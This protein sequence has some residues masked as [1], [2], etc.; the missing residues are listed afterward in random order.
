MKIKE[1][2]IKRYGPLSHKNPVKLSDFN[3][4]W[5]RNEEGKTLTIDALVKFILGKKYKNKRKK[6][7]FE[8]I[9]RVEEFP[10]GYAVI[11]TNNKEY[12]LGDRHDLLSLRKDLSDREFRNIFVIR[13][14]D[15][16]LY[17]ESSFYSSMIDK[18]TG[19]RT[20]DIENLKA[21][22]KSISGLTP[23]GDFKNDDSS[24]KLKD[25]LQKARKLI[26]DIKSLKK[27]VKEK[28][29]NKL[30]Y[31]KVKLEEEIDEIKKKLD[32]L[33]AALKKEKYTKGKALLE[34]L[35]DVIYKLK[36]LDN[37]DDKTLKEWNEIEKEMYALF[38]KYQEKDAQR[39]RL[40]EQRE[41]VEAKIKEIREK[42]K[43][44]D[45][46]RFQIEKLI[47][48]IKSY[49]VL[50]ETYNP[51]IEKG[52]IYMPVMIFSFILTIIS[53]FA[54]LLLRN[55]VILGTTI[56]FLALAIVFSVLAMGVRDMKAQIER[57]K[58]LIMNKA[59]RLNLEG[60]EIDEVH[61]EL[62]KFEIEY[63][64]HREDLNVHER[65]ATRISDELRKLREEELP[66]ISTALQNANN[67]L[68]ELKKKCQ[69]ESKKDLEEKVNKKKELE[70]RMEKIQGELAGILGSIPQDKNPEDILNEWNLKLKEYEEYRDFPLD[71]TYDEK[72]E[73]KLRK[74]LKSKEE[75]LEALRKELE[76][77][78]DEL[79]EVQRRAMEILLEEVT[80][81][82]FEHLDAVSRKLDEFIKT[83]EKLRENAILSEEILSEIEMEE[84]EQFTFLFGKDSQVSLLFKEVTEGM[85]EEVKYDK[86][87]NKI[88]VRNKDGEWLDTDKLSGGTF[89]QLYF[90]I[91]VALGENLLRDEKGF[92]ILDDP[93]V[94]SDP[95]RLNKQ[96]NMLRKII[97]SGWQILYFSCKGEVKELL[98]KDI[99][100]GKIQYIEVA[101]QQ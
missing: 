89:D 76:L 2:L 85:Y 36:S 9:D 12:K 86:D 40:K 27:K 7:I 57:G 77:F 15:L 51:R 48:D 92:F 4:L 96:I 101:L 39:A 71:L 42:L 31:E 30:E 28:K 25:R 11:E 67:K 24:N 68:E 43:I 90:V 93:F 29:W 44:A 75:A 45:S 35:E 98:K 73:D 78:R 55:Y 63:N 20:R 97:D 81:C 38:E 100:E 21:L 41:K 47:D 14:S 33:Q 72:K 1:F 69:V 16:S 50:K 59:K 5:G 3:I 91:R 37:I 22:V 34:E 26:E 88:Y 62:E 23:R 66:E 56:V 94:K 52:K 54:L 84:K 70:K 6:P 53:F 64:S 10:E 17:S 65:E 79:K 19:M 61:A 74:E 58:R 13:N 32:D 83:Q 60:K 18:L 95:E 99:K 80:S 87:E 82:S 8:K 49:E 46:K